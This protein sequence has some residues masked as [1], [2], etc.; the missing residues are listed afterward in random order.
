[1]PITGRI[2][3]QPSLIGYNDLR[4]KRIAMLPRWPMVIERWA[5]S[6]GAAVSFREMT[7]SM[8]LRKWF[9]LS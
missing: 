2:G 3:P 6:T 8:K 9:W 7:Q 5:V 4:F 1:M